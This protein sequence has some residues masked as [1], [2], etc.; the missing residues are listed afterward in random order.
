MT[1]R[2]ERLAT[3]WVIALAVAAAGCSDA[4][5]ATRAADPAARRLAGSWEIT[6]RSDRHAP[7]AAQ[8]ADSV[9]GMLAFTTAL[10]GP[11]ATDQL[12]V[13]TN[14]GAYDLDPAP[15]GI[16]LGRGDGPATAVARVHAAG[17]A[18]DTLDIVI[19][20][21]A[22]RTSVA[23]AGRL[24]G[25]SAAGRWTASSGRGAGGAGTFSMHRRHEH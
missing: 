9:A 16:V 10:H 20:P 1:T 6:L 19:N 12:T 5:R 8:P 7:L 2:G 14:Q 18:G 13:I 17:P 21:G 4:P 3:G 25:D 11:A 23:L 24:R 15:L 22:D